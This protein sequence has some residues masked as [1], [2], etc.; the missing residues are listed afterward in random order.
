MGV[1]MERVVRTKKALLVSSFH[2]EDI[3]RRH[4]YE[5]TM[6]SKDSQLYRGDVTNLN[7]R[8]DYFDLIICQAVL[9]HVPAYKKGISEMYRVLADGGVLLVDV[10]IRFED[11]TRPALNDAVKDHKWQFGRKNLK[12]EFEK[13]DFKVEIVREIFI[14][15]KLKLYEKNN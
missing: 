10:P 1:L 3:L 6:V 13:V 2:Y 4:G 9:E 14:C 12:E 11:K 15:S 7:F 8:D 5:V